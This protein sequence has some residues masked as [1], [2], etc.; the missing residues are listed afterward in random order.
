M[1]QA[2]R[3]EASRRAL[4]TPRGGP[5]SENLLRF[6]TVREPAS[7]QSPWR[8]EPYDEGGVPPT[9]LA[10][11]IRTLTNASAKR[12]E[13]HA[14][15][16]AFRATPAYVGALSQI[17]LNLD[18]LPAWIERHSAE[19]V[20]EV[21]YGALARVL[22]EG[23]MTLAAGGELDALTASPTFATAYARLHDSILADSVD[24]R[25]RTATTDAHQAALKVLTLLRR[26]AQDRLD[27][28]DHVTLSEWLA[29]TI[30]V[31]ERVHRA[32]PEFPPPPQ[33]PP[34]PPP[35]DS[36]LRAQALHSARRAL[37][38]LTADPVAVAVAPTRSRAGAAT[39][40]M[41]PAE[42]IKAIPDSPRVRE[43]IRPDRGALV[44]PSAADTFRVTPEAEGPDQARPQLT[45]EAVR[46]LDAATVDTL[47][48]VGLPAEDLDPFRA[49]PVLD[50]AIAAAASQVTPRNARR[51]LAL[52]GAVIDVDLAR[53]TLGTRPPKYLLSAV[54]GC[55]LNAGVGDLLIVRQDLKA[56]E[57]ADFAHVENVLAGEF[58][59]RE[60]RRLDLTEETVT[61]ETETTTEKERDLQSTERNEMQSEMNRSVQSAFGIDA[62][63][64]MSGSYGPTVSFS[65]S[66]NVSYSTNV[67]ETQRKAASFSRE[68]TE[69]VSDRVRERVREEA[70]RR[71]LR[72][73]EETNTHRVD[74][75]GPGGKHVRGIYR[76]LNKIYDAQVFN[77]GQRMMLEFVLPEPAAYFV[78]AMVEDPP[79]DLKKPDPPTV[80]GRPLQPS[81]LTLAE[82]QRLIAEYEVLD[83]PPHP[84]SSLVVSH[85]DGLEG[86]GAPKV[87]GRGAKLP[88]PAGYSSNVARLSAGS[89]GVS[90]DSFMVLVG[91]VNYCPRYDGLTKWVTLKNTYTNEISISVYCGYQE[92]YV[93]GVDLFCT[94]TE[95]GLRKWQQQTYDAIMRSYQTQLAEYQEKLA[96][97]EIQKGIQV[98]GRNPL[99]NRRLERDELKKLAIIVLTDDTDPSLDGFSSDP[100]PTLDVDA[101]CAAGQ[102]IR[103]FE[104]AFEWSN[105]TYV[106]YPYFWGRKARWQAALA[107]TDPDPD[108][109]AFL[110]AG[111]ARVQV[112]VRSGFEKAMAYY[113]QTGV[114]WNGNDPPL[115]K[116]DLYVPIVEEIAESLGRPAAVTPYP[117]NSEPWE[118]RVPT[119]L[120]LVQNLEEIPGIID[121]LTGAPTKIV[122]P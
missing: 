5:M 80:A 56:Y 71:T 85:F 78:Y 66:L 110:K 75:A 116:D 45:R 37:L 92:M 9:P 50:Q 32:H 63:L 53:R 40:R 6:L 29:R 31:L 18:A 7:K 48:S 90:L 109:A 34:P 79:T 111:A 103:F 38:A 114:I 30:L 60:H 11:Q 26:A 10:A 98:L 115:I 70:R 122:D 39:A 94:L 19:K 68:V 55:Q 77:Y 35:D 91:G 12:K 69:R 13:F 73:I 24:E 52:G 93:L 95:D 27:V 117:E 64:Q 105:M 17:P 44:M 59:Q 67:E 72:Q 83:A 99:E 96:A 100:E 16:K 65:S 46:R 49:L 101:S 51:M 121:T 42:I 23:H 1:P 104:N 82:A 14:V 120:V 25:T 15:G 87:L 57:L 81:H 102:R 41:D 33:P 58:R 28:A 88:I 4:R 106:F 61:V 47:K 21:D 43:T 113:L 76:W 119:S 8:L 54:S 3:H 107:L 89:A 36:A 74:N 97:L 22:A 84:P 108:F 2:R 62:G 86:S 20:R 112:P 118:V